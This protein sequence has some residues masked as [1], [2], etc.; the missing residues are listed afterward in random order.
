MCG[1]CGIIGDITSNHLDLMEKMLS[2]IEHRGPDDKGIYWDNK[3]AL[4]MRRLSII[5]LHTGKQP[6]C[7]EDKTVWVILNGEIY[8]YKTLRAELIKKGHQ[9]YTSSDT[10]VLVHLYEEYQE[11]FVEFINGMFSIA[12]YD[13]NNNKLMLIRDRFGKK[14]LYYFLCKDY[15]L[16]GSEI[17]TIL[18]YS[19]LKKEINFSSLHHYLT[20]KNTIAPETIYKNIFSLEPAEMLILDINN[21]NNINKKKYWHLEYNIIDYSSEEEVIE[22]LLRKLETA[23]NLRITATDVP[24]GAYLSG[25]VDSS[26]IVA[27]ISHLFKSK[28]K[29][30]SLS[31]SESL[32]NKQDGIF[33]DKVAQ[34]YATEHYEYLMDPLELADSSKNIIKHFDEPYAGVVASYFLSKLVSKHVK[35]AVSGDGA[36]DLFGSYKHQRLAYPIY[37]Y[38]QAKKENRKINVNEIDGFSID[39]IESIAEK[40]IWD[41]RIKFGGIGGFSE[42]E[43]QQLYTEDIIKLTKNY[44]STELL[45]NIALKNS[46]DDPLNQILG[47]DLKLILSDQILPYVDRL[48]MAHSIEVRSPFLDKDFAEFTATIPSTLKYKNG[49]PKY[50]LKKAAEKYLPKDLLYRPKEGFVL[51]KDKWFGG[52]LKDFVI[53]TL[54][55]ARINS[56][57]FFNCNYIQSL[58]DEHFNQTKDNT[59][60]IWILIM[61]QIWFEE[62]ML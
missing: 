43:K 30:F 20:F 32:A 9:F 23:V 8:N 53:Q 11:N 36:D 40:N 59:W 2:V 29:T 6:I 39:Y 58:L 15:M 21:F 42:N 49:I 5:D 28:L 56:H 25:G 13:K 47:I 52:V 4:G 31:Y 57:G 34:M 16:F 14:P 60:K 10:E 61:F 46:S 19:E 33:A 26:L 1:I 44:N 22:E 7:N 27:L 35:I 17:K 48:S 24:F 18:Q 55:P 38:L 37:N 54:A 45:K 12:V 3:I 51:P 62:Y 41:W 50:I